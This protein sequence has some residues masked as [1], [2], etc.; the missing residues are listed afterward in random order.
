MF[1]RVDN[2]E[3]YWGNGKL[4]SEMDACGVIQGGWMVKV[5]RGCLVEGLLTLL[6]FCYALNGI[7][8]IFGWNLCLFV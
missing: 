7:I 6:T 5:V 3:E 2:L 4:Q 8:A 1:G